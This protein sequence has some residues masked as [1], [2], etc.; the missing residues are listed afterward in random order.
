MIGTNGD[1]APETAKTPPKSASESQ[2]S[3]IRD[4][5]EKFA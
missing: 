2:K 1:S 4:V 5:A 3:A